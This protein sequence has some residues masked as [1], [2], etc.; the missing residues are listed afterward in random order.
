MAGGAT[1]RRAGHADDLRAY[2]A[3]VLARD[4]QLAAVEADLVG[5][6]AKEPF[7]AGVARLG[8]YR[9]GGGEVC[10]WRRFGQA[11]A[12]MGFVGLVPSEYSKWRQHPTGPYH[13]GRQ[14]PSAHPAGRG[15]LGIPASAFGGRRVSRSAKRGCRLRWWP[16][17]T[18]QLRLCGRFRHLAAKK[19]IKSVVAAAVAR[20]L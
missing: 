15:R 17:L 6:F 1:F 13:P 8:A 20:E 18:A 2:R 4:A 12:L 9:G 11:S 19:N 3:V 10:D 16:G 14:R 5:Y 7:A